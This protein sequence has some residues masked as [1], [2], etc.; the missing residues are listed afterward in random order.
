MESLSS[1][2]TDAIKKYFEIN[3]SLPEY[4]FFFRD[5]VGDGQI[6]GVLD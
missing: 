6:N 3:K 2:I 1:L 5:G 4:I